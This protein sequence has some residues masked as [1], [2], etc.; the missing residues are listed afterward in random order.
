MRIAI[1][2]PEASG[3]VTKHLLDKE[4]RRLLCWILNAG[5]ETFGLNKKRGNVRL[6]AMKF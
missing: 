3:M 4:G 1:I 6:I 2:G 5:L